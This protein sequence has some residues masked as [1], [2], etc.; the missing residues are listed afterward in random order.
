[1]GRAVVTGAAGFI[2]S[3]L[4]ERLLADGHEVVG[5]DCFTD[6]YRRA[7]KEQNLETARKHRNFSF[8]ELDLVTADLTVACTNETFRITPVSYDFGGVRWGQTS[9][10]TT[11]TVTNVT[12]Q[13]LLFGYFAYGILLRSPSVLNCNGLNCNFYDRTYEFVTTQGTCSSDMSL[14]AGASCSFD[15]RF[16]PL[17]NGV[18]NG[19]VEVCTVCSVD[20][21][22]RTV[23]QATLAGHGRDAEA[24]LALSP[25]SFDFGAVQVN[26][27]SKN[28]QFVAVNTGPDA[29]G[30]ISVSLTGADAADFAL[31]SKCQDATLAGNSSASCQVDVTF[32]PR[33]FGPRTATV[34]ITGTPGG[35]SS[36]TLTGTGDGVLTLAPTTKDFGSVAVGQSGTPVAFTVTNAGSTDV[37]INHFELSGPNFDDFV[38]DPGSCGPALVPT[39]SC[40]FTVRFT[41]KA[42]GARAAT[43]TVAGTGG[44]PTVSGNLTGTGGVPAALAFTPASYDFGNRQ[45]GFTGGGV[46]FFTVTNSGSTGTA[47]LDH[48]DF[49]G[50]NPADFSTGDQHCLGVSLAP[51][52]SC[53]L[54][55]QFIPHATGLRSATM[56]MSSSTDGASGSAQVT[57][58]GVPPTI[59]TVT[60]PSKNF[61]SVDLGQTGPVFA[62]TVTNTGPSAGGL[63]S[64]D[65]LS[66]VGKADYNL[67]TSECW[68]NELNVGASCRFT[69]SFSPKGGGAR[70]ATYYLVFQGGT[71]TV[72]F[73]G[74]G[75]SPNALLT[76]AP[77]SQD[78]G[79]V[80]LGASSDIKNFTV[81]NI[82]RSTSGSLVNFFFTGP[83]AYEFGF[84]DASN[85]CYAHTLAPGASCTIGLIFSPQYYGR[86]AATLTISDGGSPGTVKLTGGI[87][88][89]GVLAITPTS[90]NFGTIPAGSFS[91]PTEFTV[92]N[93]GTTIALL[94]GVFIDDP[95]GNDYALEPGSLC[96]GTPFVA[97]GGSC[98]ILVHFAPRRSGPL[99]ATLLVFYDAGTISAALDGTGG[100]PQP[101]APVV[102]GEG[103]MEL[104]AFTATDAARDL[105]GVPTLTAAHRAYL[106]GTGNHDGT[107]NLGDLLAFL[108]RHH[109]KLSP[110][111]MAGPAQKEGVP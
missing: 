25:G 89:G 48:V 57:G 83:G 64:T 42:T 84:L 27:S 61:G 1:M 68:G 3:H 22:H 41:P 73:T 99:P 69:V 72:N 88:P 102:V 59:L 30:P 91:L 65:T 7:R 20:D 15:V 29:S 31:A 38:I 85:Q 32:T 13:P 93:T 70:P 51:G 46:H 2:G 40:T 16:T 75:T 5:V 49:T 81:T 43:L 35:T 109:I 106:D 8:E 67:L 100:A 95:A 23:V 96:A 90:K 78:F 9:V 21:L 34:T 18:Q 97:V 17:L 37:L 54:S 10:P 11:L 56:T 66:G 12:E 62:F 87:T 86:R 79:L 55:V 24:T 19:T 74:V 94:S 4:S 92:T 63:I 47:P 80:F 111:L 6:Y 50:A 98:N 60:P 104:T 44:A 33:G 105:L 82:G 76:V 103:T 45:V 108:D 39:G 53:S 110:A 52:A 107:Y 77:D 101:S 58:A 71:A 26:T 28:K 36:V 14:A